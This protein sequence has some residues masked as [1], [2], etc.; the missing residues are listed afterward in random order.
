MDVAGTDLDIDSKHT[1]T[2]HKLSP[3][4]GI[5]TNNDQKLLSQKSLKKKRKYTPRKR[6]NKTIKKQDKDSTNL[7]NI[8]HL[9]SKCNDMINNGNLGNNLAEPNRFWNPFQISLFLSILKYRRFFCQMGLP[10]SLF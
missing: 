8:D 4:N 9:T 10:V 3:T 1:V 7:E 2:E 6:K 5:D